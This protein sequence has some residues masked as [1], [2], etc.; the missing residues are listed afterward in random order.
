MSDTNHAIK[1]LVIVG[2]GTAG[3]M[4]AALA[5]KLMGRQLSIELV[6]SDQIGT[7]G[8]GEA[9]IPPIQ[10][11]NKAVGIEENAFLKATQG[12]IK[13]GIE[14]QNWGA[15]GD[16]YMHAF[17]PVGRRLGMVPF[18]HYWLRA[19]AAG[20]TSG[21][22]DYSFNQQAAYAGKYDRMAKIPGSPLDGLSHAF[23]FDAGLYAKFLRG[24]SKNFGI[25]RTEGLIEKVHQDSETGFVTS[26]ELKGGTLVQGDLF[27]DCT[28]FRGLLI[29]E[30]LKTGYEDWSHYLPCDRAL[31]V[32]S[33]NV[34]PPRPY[35]Q[36]IAHSAG[37]QWRIPLQ[38]R[39]GNGHVYCSEFI[40]DDEATSVLLSNLE[41]ESLKDP[42]IIPF[43]TGRRKKF[44]NKN[45]VA[46]G[47]SS[48]FLEPLESTS[49]HLIQQS[50]VRLM[51]MF[52]TSRF[53][54]SNVDE[55]NN[56]VGFEFD[57][58]R[59]F[60]I[61]HYH[62]NQRTDSLF[63]QRCAQMEIPESLQHRLSLFWETGGIFRF[64]NELFA[65]PAWLQVLIGQGIKPKSFS[66]LARDISDEELSG[67]FTDLKTIMAGGLK[68]LP[69]HQQYIDRHCA[70]GKP[71]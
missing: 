26:V 18:H 57:V 23:H 69:S 65:E 5:G 1:K 41:G 25:K 52:P 56:Q 28:G 8:V 21:L 48:G 30:T 64:N 44:W 13:L 39:T 14:F 47:L 9:T 66:Q 7:V 43:K 38:H 54:Q 6:E 35:T 29:E 37:W 17:G 45:V 11:F 16:S 60:I 42:V 15:H 27:V 68:Q 53:D 36:S 62:V 61:L 55:Y 22:W 51:R 19:Q 70:A 2:G 63:W 71:D 31:A 33:E 59:D 34:G 32:P 58:I 40:S 12:T 50:L 67:F 10:I 49:I 3:W 4:V 24:G 46:I 20:D